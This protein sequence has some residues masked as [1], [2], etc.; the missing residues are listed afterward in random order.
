[1]AIMI[2]AECDLNQRPMSER[3]VFG[4][5]KES[6]S[7]EWKVF[8]SFDFISRNVKKQTFDGE[9]DFMLYHPVK[10]ILVLE[11]KG[12]SISYHDGQ[13]YQEN[14]RIDPV[15]Q[16]RRGKYAILNL[17]QNKLKKEIPIRFAH[18]VCFPSCSDA[19]VWPVEAQDIVLTQT[20]LPY[21]EDFATA[22][23]KSKQIPSRVHSDVTE[24]DIMQILS[25]VFEYGAKL[26]ERISI[27]EKQFF[28]FTEQQCAVLDALVHYKRLLI[29]GCAGSGKTVLAL[30]KAERLAAEGKSVLLLCF[31]QLLAQHL[32]DSIKQ[33]PN[34]TVAAFFDYC[35][36]LL[37]CSD[38]EVRECSSDPELYTEVLPQLLREYLAHNDVSYDAIIVDEGQDFTPQ[39]WDVILR[40][41]REESDFYI[42][43]DPDQNI[44]TH[45]LILP[46]FGTP[47]VVLN[48]NCRNTKRIFEA[49]KPFQ[50]VDAIAN[51]S[52]PIGSDVRIL[53]G[54][55]RKNLEDELTRLVTEEQVSLDDIVILGGHSMANTWP[56]SRPT[57]GR[58]R[59]VNREAM[60]SRNEVAF[61]TYMKYKGCESKVVILFEVDDHDPRWKD[62]RGLYTAMSRAVHQL[63]ILRKK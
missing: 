1:M 52:A 54:N 12:G 30:K 23:L 32:R 55:C 11:V 4:I 34:V 48:K 57:A 51:D 7:D 25:P 26:R 59:I 37:H 19:D 40:L 63:I 5:I 8:H 22:L 36:E 16:A 6:L 14:R 47:P 9:I 17:L 42:F 13:W 28:H 53:R 35:I 29:R 3:Q 24:K 2:P 20:S 46:D 45:E 56:D 60:S 18:A 15:E 50:T 61:Y 33:C 39:V 41:A 21:I 49:I 27:E 44:Y 10:G 58:F 31:N 62:T 38:E 43:Y